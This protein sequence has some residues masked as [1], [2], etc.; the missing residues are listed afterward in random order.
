MIFSTLGLWKAP[1]VLSMSIDRLHRH[2]LQLR[3]AK[4]SFPSVYLMAGINTDEQVIQHK[5]RTV[6]TH[7]ERLVFASSLVL[8]QKVYQYRI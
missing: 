2:A 5:G 3:Q 7:L 8:N 4:L 6:M 1:W